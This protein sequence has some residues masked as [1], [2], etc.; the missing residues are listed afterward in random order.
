MNKKQTMELGYNMGQLQYLLE[1]T[2]TCYEGI[3]KEGCGVCP[4]CKLRNQ[5]IKDFLSDH[6]DFVFSYKNKIK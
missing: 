3:P 4:A 1:H 6:S 2:I 5:G